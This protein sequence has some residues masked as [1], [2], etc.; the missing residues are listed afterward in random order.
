MNRREFLQAAGITAGTVAL[1]GCAD[2]LSPGKTGDVPLGSAKVVIVTDSSDPVA[3]AP[4]AQWAGDK[5]RAALASKGI[6]VA[7]ATKVDDVPAG[8][9]CIVAAGKTTF[10]AT[11]I[12]EEKHIALPQTSESLA[13]IGS[14]ANNRKI[15]LAYGADPRALS[16]ALTELAGAVAKS[17]EPLSTL[18]QDRPT[19]EQPANKVRGIGR[20]FCSDVEDKPWY[21][22]RGFW[23]RYLDMLATNRFN[24]FHLALGLGYDTSNHIRD[25]YFYFPYPFLLQP[26]GYEVRAKGLPDSERDN[27]L[28][29]LRFIA[30]QCAQRGIDFQLGLWGHQ[31]VF[32]NSPDV[33]HPIE[34]LSKD[35]HA[36]YCR[37]ALTEL[38]QSIP[39]IAGVTFRIHGESGIAEGSYDFWKTVMVGVVRT[40]RKTPIEMHAKGS[41]Q[42]IIDIALATG[43]PVTLAPKYWAEH[44]G[45]P[46]VQTAIRPLELPKA[47]RADQGFFA[48]SSGSRSFTRYGYADLLA[49]DRKI[50]I[51]HRMWPGTQRM[52]L[53]G[54]PLFASAY[55]KAFTF[56]GSDGGEFFEPLSFKGRMGSGQTGGREGYADESLKTADD[57]EKYRYTYTLWGRMLYNP[58][59]RPEVWQ[60]VLRNDYGYASGNLEAALST[61]SRI[62][63][64]L[65]TAHAQSASYTAWWVELS[66]N[67]PIVNPARRHPFGDTPS[68]KSFTHVSPLDPQMFAKIDDF[69]AKLLDGTHEAK[70]TPAEVAAWLE[71]LGNG[72]L[73]A[74]VQ[75]KSPRMYR[76]AMIDI[77]IQSKMGIFFAQKLRAGVLWALFEKSP[78]A[79]IANE[80]LGRYRAARQAWAELAEKATGVYRDDITYGPAY[81]QHGHWKDRLEAI[82]GDIADMDTYAKRELAS[83]TKVTNERELI[84][85]VLNPPKRPQIAAEHVPPS[86]FGRGQEVSITL[87]APGGQRPPIV[88]YRRVNQAETF[89]SGDMTSSGADHRFAIPADYTDSAFPLQ[90]YFELYD[91]AGRACLFP[92]FNPTWTNQPYYVIRQSRP[93]TS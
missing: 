85:A 37:D 93:S 27:N 19:V 66:W 52:L 36:N 31:Y 25:S 35:N 7:S 54:D 74:A 56:C 15:T 43:S 10:A 1:G 69:A 65:T 40:G 55:G 32:D 53:W 16:Y 62:L 77:F 63:P 50:H 81:F 20:L 33:N 12:A 44:M 38:L 45:L 46:Y 34:G 89:R 51:V 75:G 41:D 26:K 4:P 22:D 5:L 86:S 84:D 24:R 72:P 23:Q 61:A 87:R 17:E 58:D 6:P 14:A 13:L 60:R 39:N 70:Y 49:E 8:A 57:F 28:V 92:G 21:N 42:K 90:Y 91:D 88:H 47:G 11:A 80:A 2:P 76:R 68:P 29:M 73:P 3:S 9:V 83:A 67:M 78:S 59:T 18:T 82:D 71:R 64:L 30:D 79:T 48:Q